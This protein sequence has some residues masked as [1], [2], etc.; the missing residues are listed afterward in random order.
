MIIYYNISISFTNLQLNTVIFGFYIVLILKE[1][2]NIDVNNIAELLRIKRKVK[3]FFFF[4]EREQ[5]FFSV[6]VALVCCILKYPIIYFYEVK[7]KKK[8][9]C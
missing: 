6:V 5:L 8:M 2:V 1:N 3:E 9:L 7:E 4:K